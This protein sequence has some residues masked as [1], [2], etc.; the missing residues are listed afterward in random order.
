MVSHSNVTLVASDLLVAFL[1]A[2]KAKLNER[3]VYI[4]SLFA[5][6]M[7]MYRRYYSWRATGKAADITANGFRTVACAC[8]KATEALDKIVTYA[9]E[10]A[11]DVKI[12]V[13]ALN[14]KKTAKAFVEMIKE[15]QEKEHALV[16][17]VKEQQHDDDIPL[18]QESE[19]AVM[20]NG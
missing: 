9:N 5:F 8:N 10:R 16:Q 11:D 14:D 1:L 19:L 7:K 15:Q 3:R 6:K 4:M 2:I 17:E 20:V 12:I 18:I 13:E